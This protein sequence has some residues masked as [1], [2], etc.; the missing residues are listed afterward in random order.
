MNVFRQEQW[1]NGTLVVLALALA[2]AVFATRET[3]TTTEEEARSDNLLQVFD[4]QKITRVRIER[5]AG[6]FTVVRGENGE[7]L[8]KEPFAE[9][10]EPF[11]V[12]KLLGTLEFAT[13]VRR[14]KPEEVNRATFGLDAP[15]LVVHVDMGDVKY[16]LRKGAEA[17]SPKGAH[18][19]EIAGENAPGKGVVLAGKTL[20]D[21]LDVKLDDFRERYVMPYLSTALDKIAIDG[22][23]GTKKLRRGELR[24][25]FRFDGMLGDVRLSRRALDR[26]LTQ[27]ARTRADRFID[28][29]EAERLLAGAEV[30]TVT[31]TPSD[32][33]DPVG[34][35]VIGGK[36]PEAPDAAVALRK[37]P[38]RVAACVPSG[39]VLGL[40]VP[41]DGLADRT[42]FWM[43]PDAVERFDIERP[44][45]K[46]SLER[47]DVGFVMRAPRE[48]TVEP[49]PGKDRLEALVHATGKLVEAPDLAKLGLLPP[50]GKAVLRSAA[51]DDSKVMVETV[52]VGDTGTDGA[53]YVQREQDGAVIELSR[54]AARGLAIDTGLVRSRTVIDVAISD[55]AGVELDGPARQVLAR[56]QDGTATLTDPP[57]LPVDNGLALELF[58]ALRELSADQWIADK[59][60]GS[61]GLEAPSI[62]ARLL[63]HEGS[64]VKRRTLRVGRKGASGFFASVDDQP[65]VFLVPRRLAETLGSWVI[66]R[67]VFTV[68]RNAVR[69]I[70]VKT[71]NREVVL[72]NQGGAFAQTD[73]GP[74]LTDES[75]ARL[76]DTLTELRAEGAVSVGPPRPE[77]GLENP[78]ATIA[79]EHDAGGPTDPASFFLVGAGDTWRGM[80]VHYASVKGVP[81]TF[82]I[83]RSAIRTVLDLL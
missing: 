10:A 39:V 62:T 42:L 28:A 78:E 83:S 48:G 59:D 35:V 63:L 6:S 37:Q 44:D 73:T 32:K 24:D 57:G 55:V 49:E 75:L 8:L 66:D 31:M 3:R 46:L 19:V 34:V 15:E 16:R 4:D 68:N 64:E 25:S 53:L 29:G 80:S 45:G 71:K 2:V 74:S 21:E 30:V 47:K 11:A 9:D 18:Y 43:R 20:L 82:A 72:E 38:D 58:D 61:F 5:K 77:Y 52:L 69:R 65:G 60:D 41:A 79:I 76:V 33:K 70:V 67:G 7:F 13:A 12:Q 26:I 51:S 17:A 54:D 1:L 23:A 36:C 50:R 14:I 27:F 40:S 22:T 81:A 56:A